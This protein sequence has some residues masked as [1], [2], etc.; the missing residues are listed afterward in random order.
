[1]WLLL[2][3]DRA[4][5]AVAAGAGGRRAAVGTPKPPSPSPAFPFPPVVFPDLPGNEILGEAG[6]GGM[7][8]IYKARQL[9]SQRLVAIKVV[10][11]AGG[12][13]PQV[14]ARFHQERLLAARACTLAPDAVDPELP[15]RI[16]QNELARSPTAFWSLTEQ[17]ALQHRGAHIQNVVFLQDGVLLWGQSLAADGRPGRAVLNWLWLALAHQRSGNTAE[18]RLWLG[19]AIQWLDQQG[20]RMP[21]DTRDLGLHRH[22]WLEAHVLRAEAAGL[23]AAAN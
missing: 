17:A 10:P 15:G 3:G 2:I 12:S 6:R 11:Y 14:I 20:D 23:L 5:A 18:A 8:I 13:Q 7:G 1:M 4:A 22:A 16:A 19:K 9:S 21:L